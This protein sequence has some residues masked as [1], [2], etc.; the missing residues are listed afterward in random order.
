MLQ[1]RLT[2][3]ACAFAALALIAGCSEG[4]PLEENVVRPGIT[5]IQQAS[6]LACNSDA[7]SLRTAM[8][9][10][11][12]L[13]GVPAADEGALVAAEYL[14]HESDLWDIADG[15]LVP[16][17]PGCGGVPTDPPETVEIVTSP[18]QPKSAE[19]LFADFSA[20]QVAAVGGVACAR[21]L[22]AIFSGAERFVVGV[23]SD[24]DDLQQ[25]VEQGYLDSLPELWRIADDELVPSSDSGCL[26]LD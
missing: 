25:L 18:E 7:S 9:A 12:L 16:V 17:D 5:A 23:G 15:R 26:P 2:R 22:A 4:G 20:A 19:E 10:Y 13:E 8:E 14:R 11:E 1:G 3:V 21:E 6:E 24:P